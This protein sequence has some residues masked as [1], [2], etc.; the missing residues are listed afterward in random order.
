MASVIDATVVSLATLRTIA[1]A[2][3]HG[4]S[5][6]FCRIANSPMSVSVSVVPAIFPFTVIPNR[7]MGLAGMN[8]SGTLTEAM[9][10]NAG[11]SSSIASAVVPSARLVLGE[12]SLLFWLVA[13]FN[14][15]DAMANAAVVVGATVSRR[16]GPRPTHEMTY[17]TPLPCWLCVP[18]CD[19]MMSLAAAENSGRTELTS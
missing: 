13:V 7:A 9:L 3:V 14:T 2:I 12:L 10:G 11:T 5:A 6:V 1:L 17:R 8:T 4:I 16:T 15:E 18:F 19:R